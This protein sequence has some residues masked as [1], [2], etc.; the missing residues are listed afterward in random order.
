MKTKVVKTSVKGEKIG[1]KEI[2][3]LIKNDLEVEIRES[4]VKLIMDSFFTVIINQVLNKSQTV[5]F[6][7]FGNFRARVRKARVITLRDGK[8]MDV[9]ACTALT[10]KA[11]PGLKKIKSEDE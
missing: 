9:P 11:S 2:I 3:K 8:E 5:G 6:R 1:Q 7:G 4:D 10:F